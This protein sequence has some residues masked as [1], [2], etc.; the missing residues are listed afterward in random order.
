M[1]LRWPKTAFIILCLLLIISR[2]NAKDRV[3]NGIV[4]DQSTRQPLVGANVYLSGTTLGTT[5]DPD[6]YFMLVLPESI[7]PDSLIVSYLGYHDYRQ[8]LSE[9][10]DRIM[11][12]LIPEILQTEKVITVYADKLDLARKELP[13]M[14]LVIEADKIERYGTAEISDLFKLDPAVRVEGNDLDGR[15]IQIRNSDPDE[16]NVYVDGILMNSMG[17]NNAA[18]ISVI[19]PENIQKLEI[20]KG[21]NLLLLGSGAFGGVVN[22]STRQKTEQEYSLKLKSG[23]SSSHWLAAD[24]NI[25][26]SDRVFI[27]YFGNLGTVSPEIEFYRSEQYGEKTAT[28]AVKTIKQNHHLTFNYFNTNGQ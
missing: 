17:Y 20:L 9:V 5:T 3:F 27:N 8:A 23:S 7:R 10:K 6:G 19:A 4:V 2:V 24:L 22:I 1:K 14:A 16:V 15:F 13:H 21:S 11:V 25:P 12:T 18:D 28:A 26:L